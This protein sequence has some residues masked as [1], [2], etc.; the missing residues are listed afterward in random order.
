MQRDCEYLLRFRTIADDDTWHYTRVEITTTDRVL[1]DVW[2]YEIDDSI[3]YRKYKQNLKKY[4][5]E[6]NINTTLYF[7]HNNTVNMLKDILKV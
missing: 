6:H 4:C 7:K 5:K 2:E 3:Y 1:T